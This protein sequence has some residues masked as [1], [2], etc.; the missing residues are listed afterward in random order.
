MFF[1]GVCLKSNTFLL[2]LPRYNVGMAFNLFNGSVS[3]VSEV[4]C[5]TYFI[6]KV[7]FVMMSYG[8]IFYYYYKMGLVML[9]LVDTI[10]D[11]SP[12]QQL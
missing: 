10:S 3:H 1:N 7:C 11:L 4:L 2:F 9:I 8:N 12:W 5:N 6:G